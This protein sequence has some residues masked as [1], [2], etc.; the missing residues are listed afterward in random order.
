MK[1]FCLS[2]LTFYLNVCRLTVHQ[3]DFRSLVAKAQ[4]IELST[5]HAIEQ[6]EES[7]GNAR[8]ANMTLRLEDHQKVSRLCKI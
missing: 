6:L 7:I 3:K 1:V 5:L 8:L 4:F 2:C